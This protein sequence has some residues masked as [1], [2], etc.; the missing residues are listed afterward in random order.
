VEA[1]KLAPQNAPLAD[2]LASKVDLYDLV[3]IMKQTTS[4]HCRKHIS[5]QNWKN[6][7]TKY[8]FIKGIPETKFDPNVMEHVPLHDR[9]SIPSGTL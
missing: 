3:P 5:L 8:Y 2:A 7:S 6:I 1:E 9:I 4:Y